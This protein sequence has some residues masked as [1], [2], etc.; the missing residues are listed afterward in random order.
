MSGAEWVMHKKKLSFWYA[1][2]EMKNEMQGSLSKMETCA[3][4]DW[5]FT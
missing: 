4:T 3:E 2:I 1:W 5:D